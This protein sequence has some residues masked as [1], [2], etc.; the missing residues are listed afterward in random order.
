MNEKTLL[1]HN[2][3]HVRFVFVLDDKFLFYFSAGNELNSNSTTTTTGNFKKS[4]KC[5][6]FL[7][8]ATFS[9]KQES[10]MHRALFWI[11]IAVLQLD[12][13]T[14][15]AAG[16]ALLEQNLHTLNSQGIFDQTVRKI[17]QQNIAMLTIYSIDYRRCDGGDQRAT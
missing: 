6:P 2:K 1:K 16:L 5:S 13:I 12:E 14:L 15:Y 17:I 4:F 10:P 7:Y 8:I 9:R 3:P 11:A